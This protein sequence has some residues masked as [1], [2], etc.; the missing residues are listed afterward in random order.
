MTLQ[1]VAPANR[2]SIKLSH[3]HNS[4]TALD[5]R[6]IVA[7]PRAPASHCEGSTQ[8][9]CNPLPSAEN[10]ETT[11]SHHLLVACY[12]APSMLIVADSLQTLS[13]T[14]LTLL[15]SSHETDSSPSTIPGPHLPISP[16]V[17][18]CSLFCPCALAACSLDSNAGTFCWCC[19]M[20]VMSY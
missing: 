10:N 1:S 9:Q 16:S 11:E 2:A 14:P 7:N 15:Q 8:H 17:S 12:E 20:C 13:H 18:G 19:L 3:D 6:Q 4:A 5:V